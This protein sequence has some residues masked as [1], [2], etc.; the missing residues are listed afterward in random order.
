M[1][2]QGQKCLIYTGYICIVWTKF[3]SEFHASKQEKRFISMYVPKHY[4]L[5]LQAS[6][7]P[8]RQESTYSKSLCILIVVYV[9]LLF[10]HVFLSLSMY[11]YFYLC[12]LR[13]GYPD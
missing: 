3:R 10:V 6:L 9:F 11:T 7:I 1:A 8:L 2:F 5:K 13:R 12:I 4:I